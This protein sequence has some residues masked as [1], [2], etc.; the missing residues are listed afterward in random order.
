MSSPTVTTG[1]VTITPLEEITAAGDLIL[2]VPASGN[3][4]IITTDVLE[5][6]KWFSVTGF[7]GGS[8]VRNPPANSGDQGLDPWVGKIPWRKKWQPTPVLLPG[9]SHG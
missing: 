3:Q 8:V 1:L 2:V 7:P 5:I 6:V 4:E 9:K